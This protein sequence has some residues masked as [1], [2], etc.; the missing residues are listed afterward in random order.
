LEQNRQWT[1]KQETLHFLY[2]DLHKDQPEKSHEL[3]GV[4]TLI[5]ILAVIATAVSLYFLFQYSAA[6][7]FEDLAQIE[8]K[9]EKLEQIDLSQ[10]ASIYQ[11]FHSENVIITEYIDSHKMS[12]LT[13]KGEFVVE[14]NDDFSKVIKALPKPKE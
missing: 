9:I 4:R 1:E 2:E 10:K 14:L 3:L 11:Y 8:R 12:V 7:K 6:K 5:P 13:D